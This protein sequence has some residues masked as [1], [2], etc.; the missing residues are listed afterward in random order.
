[1]ITEK[2][3]KMQQNKHTNIAKNGKMP[4]FGSDVP[5]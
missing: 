4:T 3:L 1:M 2:M 5:P